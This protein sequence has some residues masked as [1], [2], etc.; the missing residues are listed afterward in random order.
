VSIVCQLSTTSLW[1]GCTE[2]LLSKG[3]T[4]K[5]TL[6]RSLWQGHSDKVTLTRSLWQGHSDK[7]TLTRSLWQGRSDRVLWQGVLTGCSE[8][9]MLLFDQANATFWTSTCHTSNKHSATYILPTLPTYS[10]LDRGILAV[11]NR[12][13]DQSSLQS[14]TK[15]FS[16]AHVG[17]WRPNH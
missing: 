12:I 14:P 10:T 16:A 5:V 13:W 9:H 11:K 15:P 1:E 8:N 7:V 17:I 2:R 3:R 4:D 6:T